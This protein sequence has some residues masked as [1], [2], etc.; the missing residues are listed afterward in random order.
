MSLDRLSF[1]VGVKGRIIGVR[2]DTIFASEEAEDGTISV[3]LYQN[4][5]YG[6]D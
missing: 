6:R 4:L 3:V 5:E 2:G 1:F